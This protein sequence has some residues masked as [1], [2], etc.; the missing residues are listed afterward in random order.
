MVTVRRL[1]PNHGMVFLRMALGKALLLCWLVPT[2]GLLPECFFALFLHT[3]LELGKA[4]VPLTWAEKNTP[5]LF[6]M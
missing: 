4:L 3:T 6:V 5:R 1:Q 2:L